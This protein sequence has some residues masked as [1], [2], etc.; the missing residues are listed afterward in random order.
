MLRGLG[1][2]GAVANGPLPRV[3][4]SLLKR[5]VSIAFAIRGAPEAGREVVREERTANA[6][7]LVRVFE[8]RAGG[9]ERRTLRVD[10][11]EVRGGKRRP[12]AQPLG[13]RPAS[14]AAGVQNADADTGAESFDPL[15]QIR[16][17]DRFA[18]REERLTVRVPRIVEDEED[19]SPE[20]GGRSCH[21]IE[22]REEIARMRVE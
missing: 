11:Q 1:Q 7:G 20:T 19:I 2:A 4:E 3:V 9:H 17:C 16:Q 12:D 13:L 22:R 18:V 14:P 5:D 6:V 10:V 21:P 15:A 8:S